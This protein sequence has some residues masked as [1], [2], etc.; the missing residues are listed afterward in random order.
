[1]KVNVIFCLMISIIIIS[2]TQQKNSQLEGAWQ[3]VYFK[4]IAGDSL[5]YE[6]PGNITGSQIKMWSQDHFMFVGRFKL[7][8]AFSDNYGTGT[9]KLEERQYEENILDFTTANSVGEKIKLLLEIRND[10]L[11]QSWP[12]NDNWEIDQSNYYV[13][14]YIRL[15]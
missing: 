8:T 11:I 6:I 15:K 10:T 4:N 1:M 9:Y 12:A 7:D 3:L 5:R 2:C 13:E 14:K